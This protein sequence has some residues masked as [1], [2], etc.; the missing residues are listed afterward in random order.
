MT[1]RYKKCWEVF[2]EKRRVAIATFDYMQPLKTLNEEAIFVEALIEVLDT[3]KKKD[4][5]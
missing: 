5:H 1:A 3:E 4:K 2:E